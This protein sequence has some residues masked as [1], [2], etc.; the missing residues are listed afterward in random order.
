MVAGE[1]T[2]IVDHT[3]PFQDGGMRAT[4]RRD[5]YAFFGEFRRRVDWKV[6]GT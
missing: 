6:L 5:D 1:M 4:K 3:V 2:V